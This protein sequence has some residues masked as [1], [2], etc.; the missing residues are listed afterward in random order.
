MFGGLKWVAAAAVS[1]LAA[2]GA[3]K[4]AIAQDVAVEKRLEQPQAPA[5]GLNGFVAFDLLS[6][7]GN[8]VDEK[9]TYETGLGTIIL[10]LEASYEQ[11]SLQVKLDFDDSNIGTAYKILEEIYLT[12]Q[13][14]ENLAVSL[15]KGIIE[16]QDNDYGAM[17]GPFTDGGSEL[18]EFKL[19]W[20]E[21]SNR[22]FL[23]TT[24]GSRSLGWKNQFY[25][26]GTPDR[27]SFDREDDGSLSLTQAG[28]GTSSEPYVESKKN[29]DFD[30]QI[31]FANR[32]DVYLNAITSVYAGSA[33]YDNDLNPH[34]G[35]AGALGVNLKDDRLLAW[36]NL[37]VGYNSSAKDSFENKYQAFAQAGGQLPVSQDFSMRANLEAAVYRYNE[38]E[39]TYDNGRVE[40]S[41]SGDYVD[42]RIARAGLGLVYHFNDRSSWTNGLSYEYLVEAEDFADPSNNYA[43]KAGSNLIF[44][45]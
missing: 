6:Y 38:F 24:Y 19:S 40:S 30:N 20:Q 29:F 36:T 21:L 25:V 41:V 11:T 10:N 33:Y 7:K 13:L 22:F 9:E 45:F 1:M 12:Q 32:T 42:G 43:I 16:F 37:Q 4:E 39:Q 5:V 23:S 26:W 15:G 14:N 44:A 2:S 28:N 18:G 3:L 34:A 27:E 31:G 8:K 17:N 35:Y